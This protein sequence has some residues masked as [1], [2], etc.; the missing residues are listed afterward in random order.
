MSVPNDDLEKRITQ[1]SV[2]SQDNDDDEYFHSLLDR[3][4][5]NVEMLLSELPSSDL[6]MNA[7]G[8]FNLIQPLDLYKG[9][10]A[11]FEFAVAY[12]G[13]FM[14]YLN[15]AKLDW[16]IGF[17]I[18]LEDN[19][20][21]LALPY[22]ESSLKRLKSVANKSNNMDY[23]MVLMKCLLDMSYCIDSRSDTSNRYDSLITE[24]Y[25]VAK[26]LFDTRLYF[27]GETDSYIGR[28]FVYYADLSNINVSID[29]KVEIFRNGI[30][31][32][33][34]VAAYEPNAFNLYELGFAQSL[35]AFE[36]I[37]FNEKNF[38]KDQA[39]SNLKKSYELN[40]DSGTLDYIKE[41]LEDIK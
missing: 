35:F 27:C 23:D 17:E 4:L 36:C 10:R 24:A 18:S 11:L 19:S 34:S 22:Y 39:V 21:A 14:D 5:R 13:S 12:R 26:K 28:I 37:D 29:E 2:Y 31:I 30:N 1:K 6:V 32:L 41:F 25:H 9:L 38:M 7:Q 8:E 15:L 3:N 20:Q 16:T 33:E 40:K